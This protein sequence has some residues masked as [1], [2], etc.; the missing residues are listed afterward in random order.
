MATAAVQQPLS[1][2]TYSPGQALATSSKTP[3]V[4]PQHVETTLRYYKP[5]EDGSPPNPTYVDRPETYDRPYETHPVTV[6][7][8]T[9]HESE[10]TLDKNGFEF[11]KSTSVEKDFV[12]DEQIKDQYYKETEQL[13]KDAYVLHSST[14]HSYFPNK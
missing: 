9:G 11:Y 10:Y 14:S 12:N 6:H 13:L 4:K 2:P 3:T 1:T 7:D 5:N 8:V